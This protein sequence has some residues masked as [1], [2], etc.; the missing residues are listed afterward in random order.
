MLH[1]I[2]ETNKTPL[3]LEL[4]RSKGLKWKSHNTKTC[5]FKYTENFTNKIIKNLR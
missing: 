3:L 5:L 2:I 4:D 1:A